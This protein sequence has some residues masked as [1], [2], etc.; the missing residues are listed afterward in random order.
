MTPAEALGM[1][2]RMLSE[3]GETVLVRRYSG[4]GASR[5]VATEAAALARVMGYQP[6]QIVGAVRQGDRRV[7]LLNDPSAAV[8]AGKVALST[9]LPL[10]SDDFLVIGG[11]EVEI[12][13]VDDATRR[14]QGTLVAL[15]IQVRG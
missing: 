9:L 1:H 15:E 12:D 14:I 2:R 13:G 7:I 4:K 3:V 11:N 10:S 5:A 8:P 6:Q